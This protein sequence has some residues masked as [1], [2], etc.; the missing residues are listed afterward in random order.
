MSNEEFID[1]ETNFEDQ[2]PYHLTNFSCDLADAMQD[3][4]E[5]AKELGLI[6]TDPQYFVPNCIDEMSLSMMNLRTLR[7]DLLNLSRT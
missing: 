7:K 4:Q 2:M 5:M 6:N 3:G 1:D